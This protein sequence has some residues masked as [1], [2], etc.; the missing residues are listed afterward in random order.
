MAV[1]IQ[2]AGLVATPVDVVVAT[3][4][5]IFGGRTGGPTNGDRPGVR[6]VVALT[7]LLLNVGTTTTMGTR[8][9]R[10]PRRPW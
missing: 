1:I 8:L 7:I 4:V 3:M 6:F 9:R 10:K 2:E 5:V